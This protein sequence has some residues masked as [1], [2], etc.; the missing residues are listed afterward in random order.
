MLTMRK[1]YF[2]GKRELKWP[3]YGEYSFLPHKH[4]VKVLQ[5]NSAIT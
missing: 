5:V 1:V 2:S 3:A 4:W